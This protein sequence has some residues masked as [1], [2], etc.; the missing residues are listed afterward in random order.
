MREFDSLSS[1][2]AKARVPRTI[3]FLAPQEH[4]VPDAVQRGAH[5][6]RAT[7]WNLGRAVVH[8]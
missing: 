1:R 6:S 5:A 3:W 4:L 7:I 2:S 8:A